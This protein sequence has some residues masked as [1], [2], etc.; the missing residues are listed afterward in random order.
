MHNLVALD[1]LVARDPSPLNG[2]PVTG[3]YCYVDVGYTA[4]VYK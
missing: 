1:T 4:D 2:P 3:A